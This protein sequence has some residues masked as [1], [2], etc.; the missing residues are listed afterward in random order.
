MMRAWIATALLAGSWLLGLSYYDLA[1]PLAWTLLVA[2]GT[3]LM[4][5]GIVPSRAAGCAWSPR[6]WG[7][8]PRQCLAVVVL[9][10]PVAWFAPW[11]YRAAPAAMIAGLLLGLVAPRSGHRLRSLAAGCVAAGLVLLAQGV[12][13]RLYAAQTARHHDLPWPA[14]Q[15]LAGLAS[16]VGIDAAGDGPL[17]VMRTLRQTHRLAITWDLVLDPATLGFLVGGLVMLALAV[18]SRLPEGERWPAWLDAA[19]RLAII[20]VVWLPLR[21]LLLVALYLHRAIWADPGLPLHVMNQF[22]S[23]WV[24]LVLLTAP[25]L[26]AWRWGI[27]KD[28]GERIKDEGGA[29]PQSAPDPSSFILYP[30]SFFLLLATALVAVGLQWEPQGTRKQGRVMWVDRHSTWEPTD[31]PYDTRHYG[32]DEDDLV[33]YTYTLAYEYLGQFYAMSRLREADKIDD[34][35]L[36]GCDVLVIKVPTARYSPREVDAVLRFVRSGGGLLVIGDH[37]NFNCSSATMND[38][39]RQFGFTFRDDVLY[40]SEASPDDELYTAPRVPHPAVQHVP[41]FDFAVSCSIDPGTSGG[42]SVIEGTRLW[43]MPP[44]YHNA[45]YMPYAQHRPEMR[46]GAF[47]QAW[48]TQPGQGR[49]LAFADSTVFS[50]FCLYQPGKAELL[51][52]LIEWLNHRPADFDGSWL[53]LGLGVLGLGGAAWSAIRGGGISNFKFQISNP[54]PQISNPRSQTSGPKSQISNSKSRVSSL[55]SAFSN[56]QLSIVNCQFSILLLAAAS[57]GWAVG[58]MATEALHRRAMPLPPAQRPLVRVVIDRTVSRVPLGKGPY[59]ED[60]Q[61]QGYA[62]LEQWIPRLGYMTVRAAGAEAVGGDA[63][64]VICPSL[65]PDDAYRDWLVRYVRDGG[66]LLVIDSGEEDGQATSNSLL[67]PFGL[68]ISYQQNWQGELAMADRWPWI[69]VDHAWEVLGGRRVASLDN[70][71]TV[72]AEARYGKGVVLAVGFGSLF[73]DAP[74]GIDWAKY[75]GEEEMARYPA[76]F[77]LMQLLVED[78][79]VVKDEGGRSKE[80]GERRKD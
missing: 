48:A 52:G 78:R 69:H 28:E 73:N 61:G 22:L 10:L 12:A 66:R 16:L 6:E 29:K 51:L 2:A 23:P 64:V 59:N 42:R 1:N 58:S 38:M 27:G 75:P 21:T 79:P 33:S 31:R 76:F 41:W 53:L 74:M 20:V 11:P 54:K 43:S 72:A 57:C 18:R 77:A 36:A 68:E 47:V 37:T 19:R 50:S 67:R 49:V 8:P 55:K 24:H 56:L 32:G 39:T 3:L 17:L 60:K 46:C 4:A 71:R 35:T 30:S 65:P 7:C 34:A 13:F 25:A 9:M 14:A 44:D 80:E 15:G 45:N 62:L 26:A 5:G 40:S 70:Q 63:L